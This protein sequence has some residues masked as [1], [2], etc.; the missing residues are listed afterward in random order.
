MLNLAAKR[1][2]VEYTKLQK[3][4][5]PLAIAAPLEKNILEWRFLIQGIDD[6]QGGYYHGKLTFPEVML[7]C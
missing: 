6:Y 2:R 1:L 5:I 3:D 4:P 7:N